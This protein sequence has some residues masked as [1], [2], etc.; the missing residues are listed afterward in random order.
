[1]HRN[2]PK[3]QRQPYLN[4]HYYATEYLNITIT[5]QHNDDGGDGDDGDLDSRSLF[6]FLTP[7]FLFSAPPFSCIQK[8]YTKPTHKHTHAILYTHFVVSRARAILCHRCLHR[9]RRCRSAPAN[10][11]KS[12]KARK[13]QRDCQGVLCFG[14]RAS[15]VRK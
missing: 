9:R 14:A 11:H 8:Y 10:A 4:V 1:M 15:K 2:W 13:Q 3:N 7:T 5:P 6:R 12:V